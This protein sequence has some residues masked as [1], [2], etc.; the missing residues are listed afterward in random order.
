MNGMSFYVF[1]CGLKEEHNKTTTKSRIWIFARTTIKGNAH[2]RWREN[3]VD[4][5][6][7]FVRLSIYGSPY[8]TVS[9]VK[10]YILC[11]HPPKRN[12]DDSPCNRHRKHSLGSGMNLP[13][14]KKFLIIVRRPLLLSCS[15]WYH[16]SHPSNHTITHMHNITHPFIRDGLFYCFYCFPKLL[17][18]QTDARPWLLLC[19]RQRDGE[20]HPLDHHVQHGRT[21]RRHVPVVPL[22]LHSGIQRHWLCFYWWF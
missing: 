19:G 13:I 22:G 5:V 4:S 20:E 2:R 6:T 7:W 21:P 3:D 14:I 18:V 12:L 15:S 1:F 10:F 16:T 17:I 8:Q 9:L 11:F